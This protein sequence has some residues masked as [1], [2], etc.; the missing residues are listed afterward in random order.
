MEHEP[1]Q[2]LAAQA[3]DFVREALTGRPGGA[4]GHEVLKANDLSAGRIG[5]ALPDTADDVLV[6]GI[7]CGLP[8]SLGGSQNAM[9]DAICEYLEVDEQRLVLISDIMLTATESDLCRLLGQVLTFQDEVYRVLSRDDA[10]LG[11]EHDELRVQV[12]LADA[13]AGA[14]LV[15]VMTYQPGVPGFPPPQRIMTREHLRLIAEKTE[16]VFARAY[17]GEG[18]L[19][20][21]RG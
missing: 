21:R 15:G 14:G 19:I 6:D 11:E 8:K 12:I 7:K 4:L 1:E 17:D 20:W 5:T 18:Y 2:P 13:D 3:L 10:M 16:C 9:V